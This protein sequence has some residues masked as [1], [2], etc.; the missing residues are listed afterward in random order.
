MNQ[1]ELNE[2]KQ[3]FN[4]GT[5]CTI[6]KIAS[7][8]VNSEKEIV[9][10]DIRNAAIIEEGELTF[11]R[12]FLNSIMKG[13]IGKGNKEYK[14]INKED[15]DLFYELYS[16]KLIDK[17]IVDNYVNNIVENYYYTEPYVIFIANCTYS[18]QNKNRDILDEDELDTDSYNYNFI[19]TAI[20][21]V[22]LVSDGLIFDE[23][24]SKFVKEL[25][26]RKAVDS[27]ISGLIYPC[28][29][30]R[31][32]DIDNILIFEKNIKKPNPSIVCDVCKAQYTMSN[33][34]QKRY[35][36]E[37]LSNVL[38]SQLTYDLLTS[39]NDLLIEK[40]NVQNYYTE[41]AQI[42]KEELIE[43]L[44]NAGMESSYSEYI[45]KSYDKYFSDFD[46]DT[47]A[48]IDKKT[49]IETDKFTINLPNSA[50]ADL[51]IKII[52]GKKCIVIPVDNSFDVNGISLIE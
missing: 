25:A 17:D 26:L 34:N 24:S 6:D 10:Q 31:T 50:T 30:D 14:F 16:T 2:V 8:Y 42:K 22:E 19:I 32:A 46:L 39:I 36:N 5:L 1:K 28:F 43:L 52:N 48:L 3:N 12:Q 37:M 45:D 47:L 51:D 11:I 40:L 13:K 23:E 9:H 20:C 44:V 33:D 27:P 15:K 18:V 49:K 38:G 41:P 4:K 35:F 7:Y 21:P 29:S